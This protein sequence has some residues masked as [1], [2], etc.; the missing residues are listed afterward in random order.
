VYNGPV[1]PIAVTES[2]F[3]Q[4]LLLCQKITPVG[5]NHQSSPSSLLGPSLHAF[6][7]MPLIPWPWYF[8]THRVANEH[9]PRLENYRISGLC[10]RSLQ[11]SSETPRCEAEFKH[12]ARHCSCI[13][14]N[15]FPLTFDRSTVVTA[16]ICDV[17]GVIDRVCWC[18]TCGRLEISCSALM[19]HRAK[20]RRTTDFHMGVD[21]R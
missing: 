12:G 2:V 3:A 8:P 11:L 15:I 1:I 13:E 18:R 4:L 9:V 10:S 17:S 16:S 21:S 20:A 19:L 5:C 6:M 7:Q 14:S